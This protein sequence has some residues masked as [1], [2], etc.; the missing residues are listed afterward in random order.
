MSQNLSNDDKNKDKNQDQKDAPLRAEF[1]STT[2]TLEWIISTAGFMLVVAMLG[3]IAM[4]A[5]KGEN[6]PPAITVHAEKI[7][8]NGSRF[9][10]QIR[11]E[12]K[13]ASTAAGLTVEG[14]LKDGDKEV[15]TST[16]T[17]DYL[18]AH[19]YRTGGLFFDKN[20]E[21]LS[22]ELRPLGYQAP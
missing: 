3:F 1:H 5:M 14:V 7:S 2:P 20:P 15:G 19:S 4:N 6:S 18:P 16:V 8:P 22:L 9:L 10:V 12:N 13:G 11:V 21:A 17:L